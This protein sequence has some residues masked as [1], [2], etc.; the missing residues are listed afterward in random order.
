MEGKMSEIWLDV[1]IT[2]TTDGYGHMEK[3]LS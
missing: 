2:S 1:A 3:T